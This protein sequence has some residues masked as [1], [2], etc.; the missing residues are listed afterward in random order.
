MTQRDFAKLLA[1]R[2]GL[3][4]NGALRVLKELGTGVAY[5]LNRGGGRLVISGLGAFRIGYRKKRRIADPNTGRPIYLPASKTVKF[6]AA[7]KIKGA[8]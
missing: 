5:A 6:R 4:L 8:L 7:K 2:T 1:T 3:S